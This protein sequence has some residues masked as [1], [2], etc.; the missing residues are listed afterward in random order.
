MVILSDHPKFPQPAGQSRSDRF[1]P[2]NP[3]TFRTDAGL[4]EAKLSY[5]PETILKKYNIA[6][7]EYT[8]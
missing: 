5:N 4:R 8:P 1:D 7:N 3:G 6:L 2:A